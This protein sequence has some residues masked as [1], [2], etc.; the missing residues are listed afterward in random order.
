MEVAINLEAQAGQEVLGGHHITQMV[1]VEEVDSR[2]IS[3]Q[4]ASDGDLQ[5]IRILEV[6]EP[7]ISRETRAGFGKISKK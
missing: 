3:H 2:T 6:E 1:E 4:K 7:I 5:C